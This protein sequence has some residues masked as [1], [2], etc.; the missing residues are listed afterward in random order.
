MSHSILEVKDHLTGMLHAG[1]AL[2]KVRNIE[3]AFG[4]AAA[5]VIANSKPVETIRTQPMN[6]L[7]YDNVYDY[8]L[9]SDVKEIIDIIPEGIRYN[10]AEARRIV[11]RDFDLF[12]EF[13]EQRISVEGAN[14]V[15]VLRVNWRAKRPIVADTMNVTTGWTVVG[16]ASNLKRQTQYFISGD[17][18]LQFDVDASGDGIQKTTLETLDLT[19]EDEVADLFLWLHVPDTANLAKLTSITAIWGNDLTTN[20]WTGVAQT[21]QADGTAFKVGWNLIKVPWGTATETG[22]VNPAAIDSIKVTI[23]RTAAITKLRVDSIMFIVGRDFDL[24]YYSGYPFQTAAGAFI[25]RPTA[26]T[27]VVVFNDEMY[28]AF[29]NE[30]LIECAAQIE[31]GDSGFDIKSAEKR[32]WGNPNSPD[33]NGR[34]GLYARYRSTYPSQVKKATS[35]WFGVRNPNFRHR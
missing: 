4:R 13:K 20:Y 17:A 8:P 28:Q 7:I 33:P 27:D 9:Q 32:L 12:K 31:G 19:D 34:V 30:C 26:D 21:L 24:K 25:E 23:A 16:T 29:L 35:S 11:A 14:G 5:N 6:S 2:R 1:S 22:S 3:H 10:S 15:K 18:S